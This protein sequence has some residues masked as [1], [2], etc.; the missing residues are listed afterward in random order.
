VL[1]EQDDEDVEGGDEAPPQEGDPEE[2]VQ[3]DGGA[4]DLGEVGRGDGE[5]GQHPQPPHDRLR[6]L[7]AAGLGEVAV[8]G[9]PQL[10]GE[11]LE[12]HRHEVGD[13]DDGEE[14]VAVP[15]AGGEVGRP[16]PGVHVADGY[17]EAGA[18]VGEELPPDR[19][20]LGDRDGGVR[21]GE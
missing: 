18:G 20:P 14:G 11:V 9:D 6:V 17:E 5:L 8:R 3:R 16:V 1:E 19:G 15:G 13:E 21:L 12:Q 2:E 7:V 10:Q 4:D